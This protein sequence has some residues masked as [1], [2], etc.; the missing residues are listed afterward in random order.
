MLIALMIGCTGKKEKDFMAPSRNL[1]GIVIEDSSLMIGDTHF[2]SSINNHIYIYDIFDG[3]YF[4]QYDT[5]NKT[6]TRFCRRGKGPGELVWASSAISSISLNGNAYINVFDVHARKMFFYDEDSLSGKPSFKE[7]A[8]ERADDDYFMFEVFLLN[9]SIIL[10]T[11]GFQSNICK[12]YKNGEAQDSYLDVFTKYEHNNSY[13]DRILGDA[14]EFD[15]SPDKSHIVRITQ[16]GGLIELYRIDSMQ[17]IRQF[18]K[19]YFDVV[20]NPDL[21]TNRDSRYGYIS[22]SISNDR[23]YALWDGGHVMRNSLFG[24]NMVHVYDFEGNAIEKIILDKF[25]SGI[26]VNNRNTQLFALSKDEK[27]LLSFNL[28]LN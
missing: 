2:I 22:V 14:N 11:G 24:S 1:K 12:F 26:T 8:L 17:L 27:E 10:A 15:L 9:D 6:V 13:Q 16:W 20:Y 25:V 23:V 18:R 19:E 3:H 28:S 4:T 7:I 21:S 5:V